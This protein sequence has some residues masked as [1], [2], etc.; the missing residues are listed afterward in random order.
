MKDIL[1]FYEWY[2]FSWW[3]KTYI[4]DLMLYLQKEWY[5]VDAISLR[6][7]SLPWISLCK[8]NTIN[9]LFTPYYFYLIIKFLKNNK[10]KIIHTQS[11]YSL[12]LINFAK[13]FL[14]MDSI[15]F[16]TIH[17]VYSES[18]FTKF[19]KKFWFIIHTDYLIGCCDYALKETIKK[20]IVKYDN[21]IPLLNRSYDINVSKKNSD[22]TICFIGNL[23][24]HK[25]IDLLKELIIALPQYKFKIIWEWPEKEKIIYIKNVDYLW[26]QKHWQVLNELWKSKLL[27]LT[28]RSESLPYV[29]LESLSLNI[30]VV[31][32]NVWWISEIKQYTD[33]LY[34]CDKKDDFIKYINLL[35]NK[36]FL[37]TYNNIKQISKNIQMKKYMNLYSSYL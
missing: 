15:I 29:I 32:S 35:Y 31:S 10:Y 23:A 18:F 28:S 17:A 16:S 3:V 5:F 1:F 30:P 14:K 6:T 8:K 36:N 4:D 25:N 11:L 13:K 26:L 21:S 24:W 2:W 22:N 9:I 34:L 27:L 19:L 37:N 20:N 12:I 7:C 33:L